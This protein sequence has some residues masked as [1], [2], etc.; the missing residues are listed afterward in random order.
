MLKS[1]NFR[2][3]VSFTREPIIV[4]LWIRVWHLTSHVRWFRP[5]ILFFPLFFERLKLSVFQSSRVQRSGHYS[6]SLNGMETLFPSPMRYF[7][8]LFH[9]TFEDIFIIFSGLV[10]DERRCNLFNPR[11][12]REMEVLF[13]SVLGH[14]ANCW[15][16]FCLSFQFFKCQCFNR[17]NQLSRLD[18]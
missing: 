1:L 16:I 2:I 9:E 17:Y 13:I 6:C 11:S 10:I 4:F 8:S 12:W 5:F 18:L 14:V 7:I 15:N 3:Q